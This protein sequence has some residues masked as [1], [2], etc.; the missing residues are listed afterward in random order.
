VTYYGEIESAGRLS[1]ILFDGA[2]SATG[3][4]S[5]A[6]AA[7]SDLSGWGASVLGA[8]GTAM[9]TAGGFPLLDGSAQVPAAQSRVSSVFGRS[10]SVVATSGD[11]SIGR[12]A[13]LGTG[14]ATARTQ[15]RFGRGMVLFNGAGGT[16][17]SITLTN[18]S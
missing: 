8:V 16:P 2:G 6:Q 4:L 13:G 17:S 11:Y 12:I 7:L 10:G 14:A 18:A 5:Y 1:M 3:S 15:R 9:N